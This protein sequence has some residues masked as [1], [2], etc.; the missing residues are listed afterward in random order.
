M[1]KL[2]F[3]AFVAAFSMNSFAATLSGP[4]VD[5][6]ASVDVT[7][8]S[9]ISASW[10]KVPALQAGQHSIG[11]KIGSMEV[12]NVGANYGWVIYTDGSAST[13]EG[14]NTYYKFT[15]DDGSAIKAWVD[16]TN[17]SGITYGAGTGIGTGPATFIPAQHASVD[18]SLPYEQT[19]KAGTY[20]ATLSVA[21]Y[22]N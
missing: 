17:Y 5:V 12:S 16:F 7:A 21:A 11:T 6:D 10:V 2:P 1:R 15:H 9:A 8:S 18:F 13:L 4:S 19:L 14:G 3:I 20:A 22:N